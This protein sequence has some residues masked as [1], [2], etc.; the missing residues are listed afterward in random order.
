MRVLITG[1]EGYVG[2]VVSARLARDGHEVVAV[3]T[4][5]FL[6]PSAAPQPHTRLRDIR[7]LGRADLTGVSAVIHLAGVSN[8]PMS[9]LH[10]DATME[11]NHRATVRLARL[12]KAAG[13][14]RFVFASTCS[15]YGQAGADVADEDS[16]TGP[17]TP[18]AQ[19]KLLAERDLLTLS[20][21]SFTPVVFRCATVYGLSPAFRSDL[22]VNNLAVLALATGTVRLN[23]AGTA[24]R[25]LVHVDDLAEAYAT[26]LR[27]PQETVREQI[28]N[29]G[30]DA[31]NHRVTAIAQLI[32]AAVP[33]TTLEVP[34]D[35]PADNRSYRVSFARMQALLPE[36]A[37]LHRLAD[38]VAD[39]V[40][41]ISRMPTAP[42]ELLAA[43][44]QRLA[45]LTQLVED[46]ELTA[47]LRAAPTPVPSEEVA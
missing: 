3:D 40:E 38:G 8:D 41:G 32:A 31:E 46:G 25:P 13:V 26:A 23:S 39:L 27:A 34:R 28:L 1:S 36:A 24:W 20:D 33:G 10:P 45:R 11:I 18:Y 37:P 22:V 9:L 44:Y 4:G 7:D 35:A 2:T 12:A 6:A 47:L 14:R 17:L 21:A 5:F 43:P 15:V 29:I 42:A 30:S 16:P 19:S